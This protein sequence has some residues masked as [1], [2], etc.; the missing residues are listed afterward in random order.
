ME[1][2]DRNGV[3]LKLGDKVS[4]QEWWKRN[5]EWIE[6]YAITW[7]HEQEGELYV[8]SKKLENVKSERLLKL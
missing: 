5:N 6:R 7:V 3:G 4:L 1:K 8:G 2:R